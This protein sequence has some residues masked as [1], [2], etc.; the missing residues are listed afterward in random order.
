MTD[1]RGRRRPR[2]RRNGEGTIFGPRK[3]GRYVGAFYAPTSTGTYK[4][5]Y[6]YGNT[7]EQARD[8]LIEEQAK[9]GRGVPV[10]AES[11][12]LAPYLDNWLES[13]IKATRRPATYALYEMIARL[14]LKPGLGNYRLRQLSVS[15]V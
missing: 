8:R 15:H 1:Q 5:V 6:V 7:W 12:K 9:V 10:A 4:R 2:R 3:D 13:V 14:Y 11:W